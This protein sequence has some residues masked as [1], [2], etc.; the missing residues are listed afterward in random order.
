MREASSTSF[1]ILIIIDTSKVVDLFVDNSLVYA[2][3][4]WP[5]LDSDDLNFTK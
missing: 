1:V 2:L 4:K 5:R 3:G